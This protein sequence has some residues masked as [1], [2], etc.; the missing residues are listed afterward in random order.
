[1]F[2]LIDSCLDF[3]FTP[4]FKKALSGFLSGSVDQ[5]VRLGCFRFLRRKGA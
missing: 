1:M 4:L 3:F 5:E 2:V